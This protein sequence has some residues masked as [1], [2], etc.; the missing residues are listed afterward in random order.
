MNLADI[1]KIMQKAIS[2]DFLAPES[3]VMLIYKEEKEAE[4]AFMV[5]VEHF[6][7]LEN[8]LTVHARY[9]YDETVDLSLI[10]KN[11][12]DTINIYSLKYANGKSSYIH[13]NTIANFVRV[14]Y[15][16]SEKIIFWTGIVSVTGEYIFPLIEK[17]IKEKILGLNIVGFT[18][19]FISDP[20][21]KQNN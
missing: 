4:D 16:N 9:K 21:D 19:E 20:N 6:P 10:S 15:K 14:K 3:I 7:Y 1:E 13:M 5:L 2:V 12:A 8:E 11:N 18:T 17:N